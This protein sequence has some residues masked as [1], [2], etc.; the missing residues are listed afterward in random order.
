[1]TEKTLTNWAKSYARFEKFKKTRRDEMGAFTI[2]SDGF[3]MAMSA[4]KPS[5]K[6]KRFIEGMSAATQQVLDHIRTTDPSFMIIAT[7]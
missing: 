3:R 4:P 7:K 5:S 1:M 2:L 6:D